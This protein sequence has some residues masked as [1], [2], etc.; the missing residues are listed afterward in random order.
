[1][2]TAHTRTHTQPINSAAAWSSQIPWNVN[3]GLSVLSLATSGGHSL[4][5]GQA[6]R[7]QVVAVLDHRLHS[8]DHLVDLRTSYSK[9]LDSHACSDIRRRQRRTATQRHNDTTS[10]GLRRPASPHLSCGCHGTSY[11][12]RAHSSRRLVARESNRRIEGRRHR[13]K[14]LPTE[15]TSRRTVERPSLWLSMR[16]ASMAG[17]LVLFVMTVA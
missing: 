11:C 8:A 6:L 16:R 2:P 10:T 3:P 12:V 17:E 4:F 15:D 1:M 7:V 9:H 13:Q 14:L 5:G